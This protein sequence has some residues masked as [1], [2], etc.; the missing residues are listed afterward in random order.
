MII[1]FP[2]RQVILIFS[3]RKGLNK[4]EYHFFIVQS[5]KL[6]FASTYR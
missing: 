5:F 1:I 6:A 3:Y 4:V 2:N